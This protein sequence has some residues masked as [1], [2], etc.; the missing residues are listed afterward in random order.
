MIKKIDSIIVENDR[1]LK[2][3]SP[4]E[5][6]VAVDRTVKMCK[7]RTVSSVLRDRG[8]ARKVMVLKLTKRRREW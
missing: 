8:T 3:P 4:K 2:S 1:K 6:R 7:G 5:E